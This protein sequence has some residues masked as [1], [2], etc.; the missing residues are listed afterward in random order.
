MTFPVEKKD[1]EQCRIRIGTIF[2]SAASRHAVFYAYMTFS[3]AHR[4]LLYGR[5]SE[6]IISGKSIDRHLSEPDYFM[7]KAM[8]ISLLNDMMKDPEQAI[9][10]GA[11]EAVIALWACTVCM[12]ALGFHTAFSTCDLLSC[13]SNGT[14]K[15]LMWYIS[16]YGRQ[17]RRRP[18]ARQRAL[19]DGSAPR[20]C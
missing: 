9:S 15:K 4:A 7:M 10:D 17:F 3:S 18:H 1:P 19:Q 11:F 5:H 8:A 14:R 20:R 13:S 6:L 12:P 16:D 2:Q